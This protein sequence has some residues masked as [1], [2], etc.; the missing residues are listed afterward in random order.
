M[1]IKRICWKKHL[2]L[3]LLFFTIVAAPAELASSMV[4]ISPSTTNITLCSLSDVP[5]NVTI[6]NIP[7]IYGAQFDLSYD[8]SILDF[9]SFSEGGLLSN[10]GQYNIFLNYSSLPG[11]VQGVI[12]S[13]TGTN[14]STSS[15]G[16]LAKL[17][18]R[19]NNITVFPGV[20]NLALLDVQLSDIN[21]TALG[22]STQNSIV[23]LSAC[24]CVENWD[25]VAWSAC[26]GGS[27]VRTCT[28][29]NACGTNNNKPIESRSCTPSGQDGDGSSGDGDGS[30][31]GLC[32]NCSNN[33]NNTNASAA[34]QCVPSWICADWNQC[35][36]NGQRIR[37]CADQ[38]NCNSLSG[39]P[40]T[41]ENCV[42][43]GQ[44]SLTEGTQAAGG[45]D[46]GAQSNSDIDAAGV[47]VDEQVPHK[48]PGSPLGVVIL[49]GAFIIVISA[50]LF[51]IK[52]ES[53]HASGARPGKILPP[54][55]KQESQ[56]I[57]KPLSSQESAVYNY[58]KECLTK[59]Y[60][61]SQIRTALVN[62]GWSPEKADEL[63]RKFL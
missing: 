60:S 41:I 43:S 39:L 13:R 48:F 4:V 46:L 5:V 51:I 1:I 14:G 15:S 25:C 49:I 18:F 16:V 20:S 27:Q 3:L 33:T 40:A 8:D 52:L 2:F 44:A 62:S 22:N 55:L 58:V 59:N 28:D 32:E 54:G 17:V 47:N 53:K 42:Y 35:A 6:S 50:A 29:L 37:T 63:L 24:L 9:I 57:E 10:N 34:G 12:L 21:S 11:L 45:N 31:G 30:G 26:S 23:T 36:P 38:N 7:N 56:T 19:T 61:P